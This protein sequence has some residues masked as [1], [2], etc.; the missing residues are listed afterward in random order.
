MQTSAPRLTITMADDAYDYNLSPALDPDDL[1]SSLLTHSTT[2]TPILHSPTHTPTLERHLLSSL[3]S[4]IHSSNNI[5]LAGCPL[6]TTLS[7]SH[8]IL[9]GLPSPSPTLRA[10]LEVTN[11]A[12]ALTHLLTTTILHNQPLSE[13]ILLETHRLL[14]NSLDADDGYPSAL[15]S[16][17]YRTV[18]V[19]AGLHAFP[20]P[21]CVA[22]GM[23]RLIASLD[24]AVAEAEERGEVD[25]VALGAEYAH[26]FVA[27]HPLVDGN[28]RMCRLVLSALVIKYAGG[29]G[30]GWPVVF[31]GDEGER[32]DYWE[33]AVGASLREEADGD[34]WEEGEEG[35]PRYWRGLATWVLGFVV[36]GGRG[37]LGSWRGERGKG[38]SRLGN[39][40]LRG[41]WAWRKG[42]YAFG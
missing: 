8:P 7:L 24:R 40:L 10:H 6:P 16:G 4:L 33:V 9:L 39:G 28:G 23:R 36:K 20:P 3:T 17:I 2:L 25:P 5:E 18:P 41:G 38:G 12:H 26:R 34:D 31:G 13:P 37:W 1:F 35:G 15:Y 29:S 42:G 11:H 19:S 21:A 14:T 32:E 30:V 27:L 22:P